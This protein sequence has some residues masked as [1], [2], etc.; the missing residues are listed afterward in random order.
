[1]GRHFPVREFRTDWKSQGKSHKI[2]QSTV[3]RDFWYL[4]QTLVNNTTYVYV[5]IKQ[6]LG[7]KA[8]YC[9]SYSI[10]NHL[11]ILYVWGNVVGGVLA[12]N[13]LDLVS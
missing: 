5:E 2:D 3:S 10:L 12:G 8:T 9:V 1:M 6:I 7:I 4:G 13:D 11:H